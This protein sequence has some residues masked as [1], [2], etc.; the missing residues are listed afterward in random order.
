MDTTA[1]EALAAAFTEALGAAITGA[2]AAALTGG[3]AR[4]VA[5][6]RSGTAVAV[7]VDA[8]FLEVHPDP[9]RAPSD[10]PN[11]LDYAGLVKVLREVR[12]LSAALASTNA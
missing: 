1:A 12:A 6:E 8:L 10:G 2:L 3:G 7:G 9:D 4:A 11:S 5:A